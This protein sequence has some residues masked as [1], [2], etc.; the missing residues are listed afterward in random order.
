MR[1]NWL[2][3]GLIALVLTFASGLWVG[4]Q[5]PHGDGTDPQ[6]QIE[7]VFTP[8][9]DGLARYLDFLDRAQKSVNVAIYGFTEPQIADKLIELQT[10]RGV[11][12]RVLMDLSQ[13]RGFAGDDEEKILEPMRK[14]GIEVVIGTS[15]RGVSYI[16]HN[17][18]TVV[19]A[20]WVE[21]GSWNYTRAANKQGNVLNFIRSPSRAALFLED[22]NRMYK[23]MKAQQEKRESAPPAAPSKRSR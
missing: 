1:K 16:M 2:L 11:R 10:K 21:D 3:A 17:K 7:T 12:V 14:A 15:L 20:L 19:D 8:T 6:S 4:T 13:T 5:L 9:E 23:H 22:W 18:Y